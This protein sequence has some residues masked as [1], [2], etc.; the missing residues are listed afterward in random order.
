MTAPT[1]WM[2]RRSARLSTL[3]TRQLPDPAEAPIASGHAWLVDAIFDASIREVP[4]DLQV[5]V[6]NA[7]LFQL[8]VWSKLMLQSSANGI[9]TP[10]RARLKSSARSTLRCFDRP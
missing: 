1:Q 6:R 9:V 2:N 4:T 3:S 7:S 10:G 5:S 8:A